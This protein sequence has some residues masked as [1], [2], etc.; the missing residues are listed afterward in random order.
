M[1][2]F[3]LLGIIGVVVFFLGPIGFFVA[4]GQGRR[5]G[6]LEREVARLR[7]DLMSAA[8]AT[9]PPEDLEEQADVVGP[10]TGSTASADLEADLAA[11]TETEPVAHHRSQVRPLPRRFLHS[12]PLQLPT[13]RL[14]R[15]PKRRRHLPHPRRRPRPRAP[16]S[17][18]RSARAGPF[19][20]AARL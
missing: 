2:G 4:L 12:R 9:V 15:H 18:R 3:V 1:D 19:G 11:V 14:R 5:I 7:A 8:A 13:H 20:S 6:T 17:R 16:A 10:A